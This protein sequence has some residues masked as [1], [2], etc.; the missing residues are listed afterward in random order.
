MSDTGSPRSVATEKGAIEGEGE[1][2]RSAYFATRERGDRDLR[3]II[4]VHFAK[5]MNNFRP[6]NRHDRYGARL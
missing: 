5:V 2:D 3:S 6:Q 4:E 1:G